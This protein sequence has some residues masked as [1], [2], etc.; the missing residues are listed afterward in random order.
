MDAQL[1]DLLVEHHKSAY[2][3]QLARHDKI[4]DRVAFTIGLISALGSGLLYIL[5]HY[6]HSTAPTATFFYLPF[7][8]SAVFFLIAV[9]LLIY[10]LGRG[11][12]IGYLPPP[13]VIQKYAEDLS[14]RAQDYPQLQLDAFSR[15]KEHIG[16]L[17]CEAAS[18]NEPKN[19]KRSDLLLAAIRVSV[20]SLFFLILATPEYLL[21]CAVKGEKPT[22]VIFSDEVKIT[23]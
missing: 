4:R 22:R 7:F 1:R 23:K 6:P 10:C 11:F 5:A 14:K 21:D 20:L 9:G 2:E 17:Y 8:F 16:S 15:V 12:Q 13:S 3:F 19:I 18:A